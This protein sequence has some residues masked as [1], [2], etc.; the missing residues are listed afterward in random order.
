MFI[1]EAWQEVRQAVYDQLAKPVT[2]GDLDYKDTAAIRY[3]AV[4][5]ALV[6]MTRSG[7]YSRRRAAALVL[8]K[9]PD[10]HSCPRAFLQY[11]QEHYPAL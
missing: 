11:V 9:L 3:D 1:S 10:G 6:A 2:G 7:A 5:D 4:A 8:R